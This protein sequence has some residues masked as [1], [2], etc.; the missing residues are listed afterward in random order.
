MRLISILLCAFTCGAVALE[1]PAE[2]SSPAWLAQVVAIDNGSVRVAVD[3]LHGGRLLDYTLGGR[4]ALY[5]EAAHPEWVYPANEYYTGP[6]AGRIDVGPEETLPEHQALW[7]G[8]WS[9]ERMA[10]LALRLTSVKDQATGLQLIRDVVLDATS[11][12]LRITQTMINITDKPLHRAYWGRSLVPGGGV[13]LTAIT[14]GSR[15]PNGYLG[16]TGWPDYRIQTKPKDP[17][18]VIADGFCVIRK[19]PSVK[20]AFDTTCGW[21]TYLAPS[22]LLFH[23]RYAVDRQRRYADIAG[24]TLTIWPDKDLAYE[25]EPL[26]WEELLQPGARAAFSEEW[27]LGEM[28]FPEASAAIDPKA[29]VAATDRLVGS[30]VAPQP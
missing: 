14:P 8:P 25:I 28:P 7:S 16:C 2:A 13:I 20:V 22:G 23:K 4:N 5:R 19:A 27:W 29:I 9:C 12:H 6:T 10:P 30:P 21:V 15:F 3:P 11:S 17:A 18:V 26:G 24:L 1:P